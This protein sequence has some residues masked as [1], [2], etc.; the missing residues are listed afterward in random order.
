MKLKH[1]VIV[2]LLSFWPGTVF[3]G[4]ADYAGAFDVDLQQKLP[5]FSELQ[6]K[7]AAEAEDYDKGYD[8][9]WNIGTVFN[10][11]FKNTITGYGKREARI[12][13]K[14]E[15]AI[16]NM[17]AALPEQYYQYIGPYLH[18]VPGMSEKVLNL[19]G[20]KETKN[21]FPTRL[22]PQVKD[23]KNLEFLSPAFYF[24]LMP[25]AWP[26]NIDLKEYPLPEPVK[27]KAMHN[28]RFFETVEKIVPMKDFGPDAPAEKKLGRSDLRTPNPSKTSLLTAA[29]VKAFINTLDKVNAFG[30][31]PGRRLSLFAAGTLIDLWESEQGSKLPI[32]RVKDLVNP[33]QR[34]AQRI[35]FLGWENEFQMLIGSEGFNLESW[36]YTCDKALKAYR[37]SRM[38]TAALKNIKLYQSRYY[39]REVNKQTPYNAKLHFATSAAVLEMYQAPLSDVLEVRKHRGELHDKLLETDN[40]LLV[41][42]VSNFN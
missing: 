21:K 29:D 39:E 1:F 35:R 8:Y 32:N 34:L 9:G 5:P 33:C 4:P 11:V 18:Q 14:N 17:L 38:S 19:P 42:P 24:L 27:A 6:K 36:A 10:E 22:A 28:P 16:L 3:S 7:Y 30:N 25:E 15:E 2:G 23:I 31:Q 40:Y 12:A 26:Y 37:V 41:V 20:I 13:P